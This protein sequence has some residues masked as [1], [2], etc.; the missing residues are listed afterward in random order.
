MKRSVQI[1]VENH[2]MDLFN[3]EMIT[4][5]SSVQN[6]SDISKVF[7]DFSQSFTVPASPT[8]N[9]I[10]EHYYNNDV[11][12]V[13]D[14]QKRRLARV[15]I[16]YT[17][18]RRGKIQIEKS[19]LRSN[20]P[21]SYTVTF[22]GD[23]VTLKDLIGEDKLSILDYSTLDHD[24]TGAEVQLR[25]ETDPATTD[26][27][28]RYPLISSGRVWQYGDASS[29][30]I[31][32][33]GGA[34]SYTELFPAVR[35]KSILELIESQYGVTFTGVFLDSIR[36]R[37]QFLWF[38]NKE[39]FE[40]YSQPKALRFAIGDPSTNFLYESTVQLM[41]VSP[42]S[43]V[44]APYDFA[45]NIRHT[46][47]VDISTGSSI[48]YFLDVY[49]DGTYQFSMPGN[50]TQ[51]FSIFTNLIN[52]SFVNAIYEFKLRSTA[53]MMFSCTVNYD[54]S[55]TLLD[56][57]ST[58]LPVTDSYSETSA[59]SFTTNT[60][61]DLSTLAPDMKIVDFMSGLWN[62]FN[63]TCYPEDDTMTF[64]IEPLETFYSNGVEHD[65]TEHII[66]DDI[67]VDRPKLY[68]QIS[69]E[70]EQCQS[71]MNR[72]FYDLFAR[73][74]GN[75]K[76]SFDYDG[77]EFNIKLP[78]ETP[79]HTKFT[80]TEIIVAYCL[81]TEPEY[82]NYVPK[83]T[84][85][86]MY[87]FTNVGGGN[88]IKFD[89]GSTVDDITDY[90]PFG[91]DVIDTDMYSINFGS[92]ISPATETLSEL[93]LYRVYYQSFLT[94]LYNPKTRILNVQTLL[95]LSI[96]TSIKLNDSLIIRDKKYII[97]EMISSLTTG[98]VQFVLLSNWRRVAASDL[99]FLV[100][101]DATNIEVAIS[102]PVRSL[103]TIGAS[104]SGS[105]AT[106]D[107][108]S[109]MGQQIVTFAVDANPSSSDRVIIFPIST[110]T[111]TAR[112]TSFIQITQLGIIS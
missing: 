58:S 9:Y 91:Q 107:D 45:T 103:I 85:L 89:N 62:E 81:G 90:C 38:K 60:N 86:S 27:D 87:E 74:Y 20:L 70:W 25:I 44:Y 39:T 8:N 112:L 4:V 54:L 36:L 46:C 21:E 69:F 57:P 92:E 88:Q 111:P 98:E 59:T 104:F 19:Q 72:E 50:A 76:E 18:F 100:D 109:P 96:L 101:A 67:V 48:D 78:F 97:N 35:V 63:L 15:E 77:D 43:L 23:L 26:Y 30:D 37:N 17:P 49:K 108:S 24:Y 73:E 33:T 42:P 93:S 106:P 82:K 61:T 28:V 6:I 105:W 13:V 22:H 52:G 31:S 11:D 94:N 66:T 34:I 51:T 68:K 40:F 7:T 53:S 95:P 41:Y 83:P 99:Y 75:L 10:Y 1:Y 3:D 84:M 29:N 5:N 12:N 102:T 2:K 64:R 71:F 79:L 80:G 65:I 110:F 47:T 32:I 55:Y 14:H 16:D 56:P